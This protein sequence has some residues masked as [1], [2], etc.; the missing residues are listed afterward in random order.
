MLHSK[1][2]TISIYGAVLFVLALFFVAPQGIFAQTCGGTPTCTTQTATF[3]TTYWCLH[4]TTTDPNCIQ[5][6]VT[7][8]DAFQCSQCT[9]QTFNNNQFACRFNAQSHA[10]SS[11]VV[12]DEVCNN[13][14]WHSPVFAYL[15]Y[16]RNDGTEYY[17]TGCYQTS[18]YYSVPTDT[19]GC[20]SNVDLKYCDTG[21]RT[22]CDSSPQ[23]SACN[24]LSEPYN[25]CGTAYGSQTCTY[26][27]PQSCTNASCGTFSCSDN[28]NNCDSGLG[29]S[30]PGS[31]VCT[32]TMGGKVTNTETGAGI[33]GITIS[34]N[35]GSDVTDANGNW[36]VSGFAWQGSFSITPAG[37]GAPC[38]AGY[39]CGGTSPTSPNP[40]SRSGT[41]GGSGDCGT[42]CN[43]TYTPGHISGHVYIDYNHNGTK[44]TEDIGATG[45]TI[46]A[47][48]P[49]LS[50]T[51]DATG[52][53]DIGYLND[54][55]HTV[56]ITVPTGYQIVG[57]SSKSVTI[58]P[59]N[60]TT[61]FYITPLYNIS[62][63]I[64][65]D[66][67]SGK[68]Y[69]PASSGCTDKTTNPD[70]IHGPGIDTHY[71]ASSTTV[72]VTGTGVNQ[73]LT[74]S[75]GTYD[76]GQVLLSG[77]YTVSF[78]SLPTDY[79]MTYPVGGIPPSFSVTVG[80]P[81]KSI[82]CSVG[83]YND[84]A[85]TGAGSINNLD[86]GMNNE[87]PVG[88]HPCTDVR[89]EVV[90][91]DY[92]PAT[93]SCGADKQLYIIH[94]NSTCQQPG[95]YASGTVT[96]D[97]GH[98][99]A[100]ANNWIVGGATGESFTPVNSGIIRT[101]SSYILTT[102]KN[103]GLPTTD[104]SSVCTT[105]NCYLPSNLPD[106]IYTWP[107]N[108]TIVGTHDISSGTNIDGTYTFP[109]GKNY[110]FVVGNSS[111]SSSITFKSKILVPNGS[112]ATFATSKDMYVDPSVGESTITS[113]NP[114][115]EGF[116]SA[117]NDFVVESAYGSADSRCTDTGGTQDLRFNLVGSIV[118]GAAGTGGTFTNQRDLCAGD[119][120]CPVTSTGDGN[121]GSG[122]S[123]GSTNGDN[124]FLTYILN[125]PEVIKHKNTFWQE[126]AP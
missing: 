44:D 23:Y 3:D 96:P 90:T 5:K 14:N 67:D 93:Y 41:V 113:T 102:I 4:D 100:N 97:F 17:M 98:G 83:T 16:P 61:D 25:Y 78:T 51:T 34:T 46:T 75:D 103:N 20:S 38:T 73:T 43:F 13:T 50:D 126:L 52:L 33:S 114:D 85:C 30:C 26:T 86:F 116:Y 115:M 24:G 80:T 21:C 42:S 47:S 64:Y 120:T 6:I 88:I 53:Y 99:S 111:N 122:S 112:T 65:N 125:A 101:S 82:A 36:S 58:G 49:T 22:Y 48:N 12:D 117:D 62:G 10:C 89:D 74:Q 7:S 108:V 59:N 2:L 27:Q 92:I 66:Y 71:T 121:S 94:T 70:T 29:Y 105:S 77:T 69:N 9:L 31:G 95:V 87:I 110:L 84:A 68:C 60:Y 91:Q 40:G 56:T 76:T 11:C 37:S 63:A 19:Y 55:A 119:L 1:Y 106:G 107:Y 79:H 54:G 39:V 118:A 32:K 18:N 81:T 8:N 109:T 57:S 45:V 72:T 123:A 35:K 104:L 15:Q 124:L 28:Y